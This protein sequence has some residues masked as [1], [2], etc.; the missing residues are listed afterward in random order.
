VLPPVKGIEIDGDIDETAR[1][2]NVGA[3]NVIVG[4]FADYI[5]VGK[6]S[7]EAVIALVLRLKE[8]ICESISRARGAK[9]QK[10]TKEP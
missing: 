8:R 7:V 5:A 4:K 6:R 1:H 10:Q 9:T 2:R 3:F